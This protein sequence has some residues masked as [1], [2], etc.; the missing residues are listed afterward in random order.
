MR[1]NQSVRTPVSEERNHG[2][3]STPSDRNQSYGSASP[4]AVG[5]HDSVASAKQ[6]AIQ[7]PADS[8]LKTFFF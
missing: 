1:M 2:S 7:K 4:A 8:E 3:R 5:R 6:R